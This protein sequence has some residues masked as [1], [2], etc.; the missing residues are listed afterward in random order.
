MTQTLPNNLVKKGWLVGWWLVGWLVV[1][2][3]FCLCF[4]PKRLR[5]RVLVVF[6]ER[7]H[8]ETHTVGSWPMVPEARF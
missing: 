8:N 2:S 6:K 3:L 5:Y 7:K 1:I 4:F